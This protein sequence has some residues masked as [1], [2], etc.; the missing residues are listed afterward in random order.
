M[1][2]S[3]AKAIRKS[4]KSIVGIDRTEYKVITHPPKPVQTLSGELRMS[5]P[6]QVVVSSEFRRMVK[7]VKQQLKL[8]KGKTPTAFDLM[9]A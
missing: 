9:S 6:R 1:R 5:N 3:K 8:L 4:V 7:D 2:G